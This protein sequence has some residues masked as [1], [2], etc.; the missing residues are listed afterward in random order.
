MHWMEVRWWATHE[1]MCV[2]GSPSARFPAPDV[3]NPGTHGA[4]PYSENVRWSIPNITRSLITL[5]SSRAS[6]AWS[7][8]LRFNRALIRAERVS[9]DQCRCATCPKNTSGYR[10][11]ERYF[12]RSLRAK[13]AHVKLIQV[14]YELSKFIVC[15]RS[16]PSPRARL[17]TCRSP[18]FL[19][20]QQNDYCERARNYILHKRAQRE[21]DCRGDALHHARVILRLCFASYRRYRRYRDAYRYLNLSWFSVPNRRSHRETLRYRS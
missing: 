5:A 7:L 18:F 10:T 4:P 12:S 11:V 20:A 8:R 21:R 14:R 3:H 13:R 9:R 1:C 15:L 6:R 2:N 17:S 16:G 19:S